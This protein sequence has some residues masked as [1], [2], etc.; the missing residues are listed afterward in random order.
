MIYFEDFD[1][2]V[3]ESIS[4]ASTSINN[5]VYILRFHV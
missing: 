4:Y 1:K 2:F 3:K 5:I